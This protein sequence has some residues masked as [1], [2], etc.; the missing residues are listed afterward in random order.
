MGGVVISKLIDE[1]LDKSLKS[2]TFEYLRNNHF[3]T[4]NLLQN[5]LQNLQK[6]KSYFN[7]RPTF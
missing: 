3:L 6:T 2:R 7:R 1:P 5:I 4:S